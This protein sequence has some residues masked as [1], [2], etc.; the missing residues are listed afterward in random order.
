V[1][2]QRVVLHPR[3]ARGI[4]EALATLD[5]DLIEPDEDDLPAAIESS[6][7]LVSFFWEERFLPGLKWLQAISSGHDHFPHEDFARHGV[8][9]TSAAGVHGPQMAEHA[10][11]L[12]LALSRGVGLA[13]RNAVQGEW[14]PMSLHELSGATLGVLGLG[15]VGEVIARRAKAWDMTVIGTKRTVD[16]YVG[17]A[18]QVFAPEETAEV[19]RRSDAVVSVLPA[20]D[21]T[22]RIITR[23][24]LE[25]LDGWFVNLGR[26]NVV[27]E[28]DIIAAL[29]SGRLLGA[30]LDVFDT[31][32]LPPSSPLWSHPRVV[33]TPHVAGLSPH[34]GA[35]LAEIV[36]HNLAAFTGNGEWR[37]RVV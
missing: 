26:G 9:L 30:G 8:I 1:S 35:R 22:D 32:P 31:E 15:A 16:G 21:S 36:A 25:S 7:I 10:F 6:G 11:A 20:G 12:L 37:N 34:Y 5:I 14:K 29:D 27:S 3:H 4:A 2:R 23:A 24:M 33:L 18:D 17:C 19:F 13:T 28:S